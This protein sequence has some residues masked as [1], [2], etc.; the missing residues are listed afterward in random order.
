MIVPDP[1]TYLATERASMLSSIRVPQR[2]RDK[3]ENSRNREARQKVYHTVRCFF[4]LNITNKQTNTVGARPG[5]LCA[6]S[7][8]MLV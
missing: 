8:A 1:L 4:N 7:S 2:Q 6:I 5:C 3:G